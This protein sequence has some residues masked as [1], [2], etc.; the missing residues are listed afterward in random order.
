M[1]GDFEGCQKSIVPLRAPDPDDVS[2]YYGAPYDSPTL[3]RSSPSIR[4]AMS[5]ASG[6]A[7]VKGMKT[8]GD[9]RS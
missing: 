7:T 6:L 3:R 1:D 2:S 5:C 8:K 4:C 9:A